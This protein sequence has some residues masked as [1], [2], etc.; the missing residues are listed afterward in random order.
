MAA[1]IWETHVCF[2]AWVWEWSTLTNGSRSQNHC[3]RS[4]YTSNYIPNCVAACLHCT[5]QTELYTVCVMILHVSVLSHNDIYSCSAHPVHLNR[6]CFPW[7]TFLHKKVYYVIITHWHLRSNTKLTFQQT[8]TKIRE[9]GLGRVV[10]QA[11]SIINTTPVS[12]QVPV[13][14]PFIFERKIWE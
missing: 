7:K 3:F 11:M 6:R 8:N 1:I 10:R 13:N 9:G 2:G 14:Y 5:S 12:I 4:P